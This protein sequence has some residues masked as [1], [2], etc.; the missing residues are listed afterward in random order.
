MHYLLNLG[1]DSSTAFANALNL[2]I[3]S[4]FSHEVYREIRHRRWKQVSFEMQEQSSRIQEV[5]LEAPPSDR[6]PRL[7]DELDPLAQCHPRCSQQKERGTPI[8]YLTSG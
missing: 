2:D 5:I 4:S 3:D 7:Q 1:L 6:F 8:G